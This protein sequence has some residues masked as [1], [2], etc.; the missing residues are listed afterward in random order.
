MG[1][2]RKPDPDQITKHDR[3]Y[4]PICDVVTKVKADD[5]RIV[6]RR[7]GHIETFGGNYQRRRHDRTRGHEHHRGWN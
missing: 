5:H 4:C 3:Y 1:L 2:F 6:Y 7:C